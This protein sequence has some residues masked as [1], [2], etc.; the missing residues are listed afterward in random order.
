MLLCIL[1]LTASW[2]LLTA[3]SGELNYSVNDDFFF[4]NSAWRIAS[5]Q[6]PHNDFS[7]ATGTS[8]GYLTALGIL[9]RGPYSAS[10]AAGQA[11]LGCLLG[12]ASFLI[13][14]KRT[15][16]WFAA[17]GALF[18]ALLVMATRQAG[19]PLDIRSHAFF[20]NRV[21]EA[22]LAPMVWLLFLPAAPGARK[23]SSPAALA[24]GL[25]LTLL[26]FTK[27]SYALI[28]IA[29]I[30]LALI[31]IRL[32]ARTFFAI[33]V[34]TAASAALLA[35]ATGISPAAWWHDISTP[36]R[37]GYES[38]QLRRVFAG[39]IKGA[40]YLLIMLALVAALWKRLSPRAALNLLLLNLGC[41][42]LAIFASIASQ[43]RQEYLLPLAALLVTLEVRRQLP[44]RINLWRVA[45]LTGVALAFALQLYKDAGSILSSWR[46]AQ[47][48]RAQETLINAPG[49]A[50]FRLA[51]YKT[52]TAEELN[53]ALRLVEENTPPD[54]PVLALDY[55]DP[56]AFALHRP[57]P[58]GGVVF[59]YPYFNF[60]E[61]IHPDPDLV[62]R[63]TPW[64]L[65]S[66]RQ[67]TRDLLQ[68]IYGAHLAA[69]YRVAAESAHYTLFAPRPTEE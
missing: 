33:L 46:S 25:I 58:A 28:G 39:T 19:E 69:R 24:V 57:L 38:T 16:P 2:I 60:S 9:V 17:A 65:L 47:Q 4:L 12:L 6:V 30:A 62:F 7:L 35:F 56:I 59:W 15:S 36:F 44:P 55:S 31:S 49:L 67:P 29:L 18:C 10:I 27:I 37:I 50:D 41:W 64:I 61:Q 21:C 53:D 3:G 34:G 43:Q 40:P 45:V 8:L 42:G 22:L 32:S 5:G 54:A 66:H 48:P 14:R 23:I 26:A 51:A 1:L 68:T 52:D 13:L 20:Y 63:G 11:I